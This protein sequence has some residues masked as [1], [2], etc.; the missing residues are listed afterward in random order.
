MLSIRLSLAEGDRAA[1]N[2]YAAEADVFADVDVSVAS[3]LAPMAASA[4]QADLYRQEVGHLATALT[5]SRQIGVAV[6]ILMSE[7]GLTYEQAFDQLREASQH[8]N[9]KLRDV[10]AEVRYTGTLPTEPTGRTRTGKG[11]E[12]IGNH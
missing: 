9:V 7:R 3:L 11:N 8:L 1:I 5:T 4:V 6:G 2:F 12:P 10:A